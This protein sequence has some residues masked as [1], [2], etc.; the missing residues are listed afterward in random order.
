MLRGDG[1]RTVA[2]S[3][4]PQDFDTDQPLASVGHR[5][6]MVLIA[7]ALVSLFAEARL[8]RT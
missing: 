4:A 5:A 8:T 7:A 6:S 1:A 3:V 2:F